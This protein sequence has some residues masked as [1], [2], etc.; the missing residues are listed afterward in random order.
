MWRCFEYLYKPIFVFPPCFL[1]LT[2]ILQST[3]NLNYIQSHALNA[4][5]LDSVDLDSHLDSLDSMQNLDS[6]NKVQHIVIF[7]GG[8]MDS[9]HQCVFKNF[10]SFR[11]KGA[12]KLYSTYD[13]TQLWVQLLPR[14]YPLRY[15]LTIIAHSW[16]AN[17]II[18]ALCAIDS[19]HIRALITLDPVGR[20][21]IHRPQGIEFW[22]NL[23]IQDHLKHLN[24][25]NISALIGGARKSIPLADSNTALCAPFH[26][27]STREMLRHSKAFDTL[28][29]QDSLKHDNPE[30]TSSLLK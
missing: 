5:C 22:E 21:A 24:R 23:Y 17:N 10:L 8:F 30:S 15:S 6:P 1:P 19:N 28:I 18:K 9:I 3:Q 2:Q 14:I 11:A 16:G 13:S 4:Q 12:I 20:N 25:P 27:A 29:T 26:H 7:I